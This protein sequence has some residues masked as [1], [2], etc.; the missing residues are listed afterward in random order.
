[1]VSKIFNLL[2]KYGQGYINVAE[3]RNLYDVTRDK[4]FIS[5]KKTKD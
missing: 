5:G 3:I 1:M 4:D 2:D